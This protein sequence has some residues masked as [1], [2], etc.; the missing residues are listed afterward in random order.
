MEGAQLQPAKEMT[1]SLFLLILMETVQTFEGEM[2][3]V[4]LFFFFLL[5][6]FSF[7]FFFFNLYFQR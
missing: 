1:E 5:V 2:K 4:L 3:V 6:L 7:F